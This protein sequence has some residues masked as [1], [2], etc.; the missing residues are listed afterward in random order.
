VRDEV[1]GGN[2]EVIIFYQGGMNTPFWND[3]DSGYNFSTFMKAGEVAEEIIHTSLNDKILVS[4]IVI[5]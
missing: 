4:D 3:I 2:I 5:K 1:R